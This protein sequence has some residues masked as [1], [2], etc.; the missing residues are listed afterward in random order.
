MIRLS[1]SSISQ[2]DKDAVLNVLDKEFLGMGEEVKLFEQELAEFIGNDK[3]QVVCV[4]TGTSALH[5]ALECLD[6]NSNDE[7]LIPS[8]TYIAS[9]QAVKMAGATPV[10]CEVNPNNLFLDPEDVLKKIS[11]NTK[12]IMPVHYASNICRD[13]LDK[14][15]AIAKEHGIR[16]IEDA[17]H[18]FGGE[19]LGEK[20]G[21]YGDIVCFSFDGIKNI[22]SG[23]G[24]AI[25]T[26]D[27]KLASRLKDARL[28]S[29]KGDTKNRFDGKRSW[30][31]DV[32]VKGFRY[33]MSNIMASLGRSQLKR[34]DEFSEIRKKIV[35]LYI[36]YLNKC[37][38]I[39]LLDLDFD[40][41]MPH[42]F[43]IKVLDGKRDALRQHLEDNGVQVGVH[44]KPNHKLSLFNNGSKLEVSEDLHSKILSLPLH[45]DLEEKDVVKISNLIIKHL[46]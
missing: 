31:F 10:A 40:N 18:S 33:H 16:V 46:N 20:V 37:N 6:L 21:Y 4:N 14:I 5:L 7:V 44:Y 3:T 41:I 9:F 30:D 12:V 24:G 38:N 22:T 29:V 1:K 13:S 19:Y 35:N 15:Y 36:K 26:Q 23:E 34:V 32:T 39:E 11:K 43:V 25:L 28:L 45:V 8:I 2:S 17:A 27:N 42:I